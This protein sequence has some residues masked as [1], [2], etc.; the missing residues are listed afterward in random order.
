MPVAS[1]GA[2]ELKA[3]DADRI[4]SL[5]G[6]AAS[7]L[8]R[9]HDPGSPMFCDVYNRTSEGLVRVGVSHRYTMMTLLGLQRYETSIGPS[10]VKIGPVLEALLND[11]SWVAGVGD[12]G[13]LLWTCAELAPV[14]VPALC[15]RLRVLGAMKRTSDGRQ[16]HTMEV[17]W[18]LTGIASCHLA[19]Y[20]DLPGLASEAAAARQ[21][22]ESN[23][24]ALGI[25]GHQFRGGSWAGRTRG[26]IGTF[27][28]QVY[29]AIAFSR[30]AQAL[31]DESAG[32]MA[33][34]TAKKMCELQG[35]LGEWSWRYDSVSGRVVSRYPI[36]S[37]HQHAMGPMML[38]S[39]SE[40]TGREFNEALERSLAWIGGANELGR[41]FV[42][43]SLGLIWRSI[44][45]G[46]VD[47]ASDSVLRYFGYR[48]GHVGTS[49][50]KV[51]YECRPYELGWLLYAL[52]GQTRSSRLAGRP[53][54]KQASD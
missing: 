18:Y 53:H 2:E 1:L 17:A 51:C 9:M 42:E 41:D 6:L 36:Y 49:R 20:P 28:D 25:F 21:V 34:R 47:S 19:G 45:L 43:P 40:A 14:R 4:E 24:G 5:C 10:P 22:L 3:V 46:L 13:L 31:E 15:E 33:L 12:L 27:A 8:E 39:V 48:Q 7:G 37:V 30:L 11:V 26:R 50:L 23:R 29:P 52:A 44:R 35:P 16:G 38:L 54:A 32:A